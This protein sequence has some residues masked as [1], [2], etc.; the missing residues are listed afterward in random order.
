[1]PRKVPRKFFCETIDLRTRSAYIT[2]LLGS[3]VMLGMIILGLT[4]GRWDLFGDIL[5]DAGIKN[6]TQGAITEIAQM[7]RIRGDGTYY[8]LMIHI[9]MPDGE[10]RASCYVSYRRDIPGWGI[11]SETQGDADLRRRLSLR[12]PFPVTVEYIPWNPSVAR[13]V[14]TRYSY[15]SFLAIFIIIVLTFFMVYVTFRHFRHFRK[16]KRLLR[17][18]VFAIGGRLEIDEQRKDLFTSVYRLIGIDSFAVRFADQR[19]VMRSGSCIVSMLNYFTCKQLFE[20]GQT[21]NLLYLPD[22]DEVIVTDLW[23]EAPTLLPRL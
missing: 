17:E 22:Q 1:M 20:S 18:G 16:V 7:S 23:M 6:T 15:I 12:N 5:L 21:V 14:G 19:G 9:P 11:I 4:F 10:M 3:F 2:T 13:V 8:R